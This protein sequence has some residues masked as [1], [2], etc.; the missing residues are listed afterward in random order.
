MSSV[1]ALTAAAAL[2]ALVAGGVEV[3]PGHPPAPGL[4]LVGPAADRD[5]F[6]DWVA[7]GLDRSAVFAELLQT[8]ASQPTGVRLH[9]AHNARSKIGIWARYVMVDAFEHRLNAQGRAVPAPGHQLIDMADFAALPA[10][11]PSHASWAQD[12]L[13]SLAHALVESSVAAGLDH[14]STQRRY[15]IAHEAAVAAEHRIRSERGQPAEAHVGVRSWGGQPRWVYTYEGGE[16]ETLFWFCG[17]LVWIDH[18]WPATAPSRLPGVRAALRARCKA[19]GT[20]G[21]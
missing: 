7:D 3:D 9:L 17:D 2:D 6:L 21:D 5:E 18:D 12:R 13:L 8:A 11:P 19:P 15:A 14:A 20:R 10:Q 16:A 1:R 4:Q